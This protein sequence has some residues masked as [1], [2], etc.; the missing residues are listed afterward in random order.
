[1]PGM[2]HG[3]SMS[4]DQ[5]CTETTGMV[6]LT[7]TIIVPNPADSTAAPTSSPSSSGMSSPPS[8]GP[9]QG[10]SNAQASNPGGD[11]FGIAGSSTPV[12]VAP[13]KG[14]STVSGNVAQFTGSAS[15]IS[16]SKGLVACAGMALV[17]GFM[18]ML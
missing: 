14:T 5:P 11:V 9:N 2:S 1:M 18:S 17:A 16:S 4:L 6:T 13:T 15:R 12:A 3:H 7:S 8:A 10:N